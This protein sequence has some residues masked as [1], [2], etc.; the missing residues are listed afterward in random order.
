MTLD[1]ILEEIKKA[2]KIAVLTHETP[3]GD[4]IASCLAMKIALKQLNKEADVIIPKYPRLFEFLP[5]TS[6][7]KTKSDIERYDLA[8]ALDCAEIKRLEGAEKYFSGAKNKIVIDHHGSNTMFGDY[9][10]VNPVAPAC[11]EVLIGMFEYFG[12]D[13]TIDL[14][15]CII[16]G[17]ITDTGGFQY[18]TVNAE[19]FEFAADLLQMGVNV[20]EVYK[21]SLTTKTKANFELTKKV[22]DRME[23]LENGKVSFT[24]INNDDLQ[25]VNAEEGD[26]EGL[27]DIGRQVEG[28]EVSVFIREKEKK[29]LYKVSLRSNE[30][31]NVSDV[32][33]M[34]GGGGHLHAAGCTISG[35]VEEVKSK[36]MAEL[37]KVL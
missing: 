13:I 15:T 23:F 30:Y 14:G 3:D 8:I 22:T 20:S 37:R 24:Y 28:V 5:G 10:F 26:H 18:S 27:V 29:N 7:I 19:T 16:A 6:E 35:S 1:D 17:L 11:C 31:V 2:E 36:V 34:L 25:E 12:I 21:K 32:T 9:N 33:M 4:A